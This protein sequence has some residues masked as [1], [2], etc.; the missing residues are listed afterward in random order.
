MAMRAFKTLRERV[1]ETIR[2]SI[3]KG[4]LK[5]GER[6]TE[7]EMA[8][9]YQIS[10]TPVR[11]AFRELAAEG[12]IDIYPQRGAVVSSWDERDVEDFYELKAL[13]ES[14]AARKAVESLTEKDLQRMEKLNEQLERMAGKEDSAAV[15]RAHNEF[16][17]MFVNA[18]GNNKIMQINEQLV[19]QYRRYRIA[20]SLT[21][22]GR[23]LFKTH[24]K[25]I[26]A[27]RKKDADEV[28]R[29]VWENAMEGASLLIR[30]LSKKKEGSSG[31]EGSHAEA[32]TQ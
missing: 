23:D 28:G 16:H 26:E 21:E 29:L 27:F 30:K 1:V 8:E 4:H 14:Y 20:I 13:L 7:E 19:R 12:F 5:P 9:R 25:I 10:R 32:S 24:D 15:L 2:E 11:E 31:L 6:L 22:D 3:V 18:C 17:S